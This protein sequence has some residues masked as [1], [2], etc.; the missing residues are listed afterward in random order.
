MLPPL[1]LGARV[2]HG[3]VRNV[4]EAPAY[5]L[6]YT[7]DL[8][9]HYQFDYDPATFPIENCFPVHSLLCE[10]E[11]LCEAGGFDETLSVLE[12]WDL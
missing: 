6:P 4:L 7:P 2:V 12:D 10:R 1:Q 8:V 5:P 11:L 3:D 9:I